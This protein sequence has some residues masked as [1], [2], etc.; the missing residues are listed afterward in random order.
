M[1]TLS[2][3]MA[4]YNGERFLQEQL[5]SLARQRRLPDEL[6][7]SDDGSSDGTLAI[8]EA[9]AARSSFPVQITQNARQLG[10]GTNFLHATSLCRG[11]LIAF[12]D[13]DDVWME[14]K[15]AHCI[16]FF[17]DSEVLLAIHAGKVVDENLQPLGFHHPSIRRTRVQRDRTMFEKTLPGFSMI[18]RKEI[19]GLFHTPRAPNSHNG[20][21]MPH[22]LWAGIL[23]GVFGKVAFINEPLV[24]YRRHQ[25]TFTTLTNF[26][27]KDKIQL[28]QQSSAHLAYGDYASWYSKLEESLL[29]IEIY[30][31][32]RE[33]LRKTAVDCLRRRQKAFRQRAALYNSNQGFSARL[34]IFLQLLRQGLY[35]DPQK[36]NLAFSSFLKDSLR[37]CRG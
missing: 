3:A 23:A 25:K 4:T 35:G 20:Q 19:P 10:Y 18:I 9:F 34:G 7:V 36:G 30:G 21:P 1:A 5:E 28:A 29:Q 22:D 6:V 33:T 14:D 12:A 11:D 15:L 16:P 32:P 31:E 8:L 26:S 37:V 2:V 17:A 24:Y 27:T 13:Q